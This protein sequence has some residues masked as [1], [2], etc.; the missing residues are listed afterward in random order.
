MRWGVTAAMLVLA[1][2]GCGSAQHEPASRIVGELAYSS[3]QARVCKGLHVV[4][5][6]SAGEGRCRKMTLE[7]A[8]ELVMSALA[9]CPSHT[10]EGTGHGSRCVPLRK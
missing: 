5:L 2:A 1:C 8:I 6:N 9:R 7:E 4:E 3:K 10:I